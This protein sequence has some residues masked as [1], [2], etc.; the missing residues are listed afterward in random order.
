MNNE[1]QNHRTVY[2]AV[3]AAAIPGGDASSEGIL[4]AARK[5]AMELGVEVDGPHH[6]TQ[7]EWAA[8]A[9]DTIHLVGRGRPQGDITIIPVAT[10]PPGLVER[11]PTSQ[12]HILAHSETGHHHMIEVCTGVAV[13]DVPGDPL[14]C[15]LQV[16]GDWADIVHKREWDTHGTVRA[17]GTSAEEGRTGLYRV[18]RGREYVPGGFRASQD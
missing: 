6:V 12:G 15:Y 5:R 3:N 16:G 2:D 17:L 13:F 9:P 8:T 10:L 11:A 7:A 1:S 14:T 4:R 18:R